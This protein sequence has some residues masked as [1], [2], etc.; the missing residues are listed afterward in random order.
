MLVE[1]ICP[2][3]RCYNE[4]AALP[5]KLPSFR[6]SIRQLHPYYC[7]LLLAI[8][9]AIVEP[10]KVAGLVVVGSGHWIDGIAMLASAY[11]LS[12]FIVTRLFR[13][14]QPR[15]LALPWF[16]EGRM[17]LQRP[18]HQILDRIAKK[19]SSLVDFSARSGVNG[20]N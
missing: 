15:L 9:V 8:P 4:M 2:Q 20:R 7:L 10:L 13:I 12:F 5:A 14:V 17:W 18:R 19:I 11:V 1:T 3:P 16:R 6:Q